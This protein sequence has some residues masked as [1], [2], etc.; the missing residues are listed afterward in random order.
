MPLLCIYHPPSSSLINKFKNVHWVG[1][2][3]ATWSLKKVD[4]LA[5]DI[6]SKLKVFIH[7]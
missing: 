2:K 1:N 4:L 5:H 6:K 3:I 7:S